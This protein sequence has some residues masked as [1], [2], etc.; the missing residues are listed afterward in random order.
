MPKKF[1]MRLAFVYGLLFF[2]GLI[3]VNIFTANLATLFLNPPALHRIRSYQDMRDANVKIFM[4][5]G[6]V[7][8]MEDSKGE[9][10]LH[11]YGDLIVKTESEDFQKFRSELNRSFAYPVTNTLWPL[12][13]E[14]QKKLKRPVFRLSR[15]IEFIPYLV[16][17]LPLAKNSIYE[18]AFNRYLIQIHSSGLYNYW[19]CE[20]FYELK[21]IGLMSYSNKELNA[22]PHSI[23]CNDV[24]WIYLFYIIGSILS[25]V[26]FGLEFL[27]YKWTRQ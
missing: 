11:S 2:H 24:V 3:N 6:D 13:R 15:E 1:S 12:L 19:F 14:A 21:E 26:V 16:F 22:S 27:Y 9:I 10:L 20:T 7:N 18:E 23:N 17:V 25:I 4:H 8:E 5:V